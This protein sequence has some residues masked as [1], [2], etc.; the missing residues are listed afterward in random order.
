MMLDF[1]V[2]LSTMDLN[3]IITTFG[4]VVEGRGILNLFSFLQVK[5]FSYILFLGVRY[6][7]AKNNC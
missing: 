3:K 1:C 6:V 7:S 2:I 4:C 5:Q